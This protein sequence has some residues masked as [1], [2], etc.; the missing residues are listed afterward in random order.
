MILEGPDHGKIEPY[1]EVGIQLTK[2]V[3]LHV[4]ERGSDIIRT[5]LGRMSLLEPTKSL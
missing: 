1:L 4:F 3:Q 5:Y 2:G